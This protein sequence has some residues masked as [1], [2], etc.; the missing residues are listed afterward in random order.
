M[1]LGIKPSRPTARRGTD[2]L[3]ADVDVKVIEATTGDIPVEGHPGRTFPALI[4]K[5][6]VTG[7]F[8]TQPSMARVEF[9]KPGQAVLAIPFASGPVGASHRDNFHAVLDEWRTTGRTV[10]FCAA[11]DRLASLSEVNVPTQHTKK[12]LTL[13]EGYDMKF[14]RAS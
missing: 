11:A 3:T 4:V 7:G 10:A 1:T 5:L 9:D 13:P 6:A 8:V 12:G 14:I 2:G